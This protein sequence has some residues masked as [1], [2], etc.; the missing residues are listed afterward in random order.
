MKLPGVASAEVSLDKG[1][2]D[3]RLKPA[4]RISMPQL[5]ETLKKSGFPTRD[6]Q[7][8]ARGRIVEHD[9]KLLLDLLNGLTIELVA[10]LKNERPPAGQQDVTV[11]GVSRA[12][13]KDPERLTL[14]DIVGDQ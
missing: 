3:I 13:G 12:A 4:N 5:R 1:A 14:S 2:A 11:R 8:E 7:I 10:P 6:A 9:G